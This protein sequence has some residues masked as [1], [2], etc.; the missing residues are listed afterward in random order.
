[1]DSF[2]HVLLLQTSNDTR[3]SDHIPLPNSQPQKDEGII[4]SSSQA[5]KHKGEEKTA[6]TQRYTEKN[7]GPKTARK[8][9]G[10]EFHQASYKVVPPSYKLVYNPIV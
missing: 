9:L 7:P 3:F 2:Q 5:D 10:M 8:E 6:V 4:S 1:M